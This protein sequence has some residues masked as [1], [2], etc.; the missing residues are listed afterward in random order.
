[1]ILGIDH[2]I[3]PNPNKGLFRL[4]LESGPNGQMVIEIYNISGQKIATRTFDGSNF[5]F[6]ISEQPRGT[7]IYKILDQSGRHGYGRLILI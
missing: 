4:Q 3:I 5:D 2:K 6:N 1:M 7:Y